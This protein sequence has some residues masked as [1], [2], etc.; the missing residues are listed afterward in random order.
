ME[1]E[2]LSRR[3]EIKNWNKI[4]KTKK[5]PYKIVNRGLHKFILA[6]FIISL[7]VFIMWASWGFIKS[8][9]LIK[10]ILGKVVIG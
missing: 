10:N 7:F 9:P 1:S 5:L 2:Y 3:E 8:I 4:E 6:Y